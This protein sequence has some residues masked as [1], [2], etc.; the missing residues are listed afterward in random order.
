MIVITDDRSV[1]AVIASARAA[2]VEAWIAGRTVRGRGN[3]ILE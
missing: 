1:D 3:V 2:G